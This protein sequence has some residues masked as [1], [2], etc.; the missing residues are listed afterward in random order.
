MSI[1]VT[2][3]GGGAADAI[4]AVFREEAGA[5]CA[6]LTRQLGDLD[7]AEDLVQDAIEAA[8]RTWPR[9]GLPDRPGAWLLQA[10]RRRGIDRL[11]RET[12]YREKLE[13][14]MSMASGSSEGEPDDRLRLVFTC[15]HPAIAREAQVALTLR[16]VMGM[17][18][19]EIARAFLVSE[20]TMAQRIVRAKRKIVEAHIPYR[21]PNAE[22][23]PERLT[24]VLAMLYL[25]YNEG[26]LSSGPERSTAR[27]LCAD[28]LWLCRL[29]DRLLPDEPEVMSLLALMQLHE[30][31]RAARFDA[32]GALVLLR[33]QDRA[34]WDGDT[35]ASAAALLERAR[36]LGS[37]GPYWLQAAIAATHAEAPS[38]EATDWPEILAL[39]G[40]LLRFAPG[41]VVRLNRAI[42]LWHVGGA[43]AAM[44]EVEAL[45][46]ALDRYHLYHA[47]RAELLRA[48]GRHDEAREADARALELTQ[49]PAEREL[50]RRRVESGGEGAELSDAGMS[51]RRAL[52]EV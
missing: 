52:G 29:V 6:E 11:R 46:P 14:L 3:G 49:N 32:G 21:V 40:A 12:R 51:G 39:Y 23:L 27:D 7:L 4:S 19:A 44:E 42:A 20:A 38:Y 1:D 16:A 13:L 36:R 17:T 25:V 28:A 2:A 5:I 30:A 26:Y 33:D 8:L 10:A 50:I 9:D 45:A 34:L 37:P 48:F 31:R 41:P 35:I 47:T 24:Q 15:C 22:M 18:T 43:A